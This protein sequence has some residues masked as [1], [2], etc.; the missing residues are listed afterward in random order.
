MRVLVP[1]PQGA[2]AKADDTHGVSVMVR[3]DT[4]IQQDLSGPVA[5]ELNALDSCATRSRLLLPHG[6][7][8]RGRVQDQWLHISSNAS[9]TVE[10]YL[11]H[12]FRANTSSHAPGH[13]D[14]SKLE[15]HDVLVEQSKQ[16]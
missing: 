11:V 16:S 6:V 7:C 10:F 8:C 4:Y 5:A 14:L 1:S 2:S 13:C 15:D 12:R 3:S 9:P